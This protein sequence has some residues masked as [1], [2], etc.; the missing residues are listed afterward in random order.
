MAATPEDRVKKETKRLIKEV[1]D[2]RGLVY[3]IDW[4]AGSAFEQTLDATG[5]VAGHP[6]IAELKRFDQ[7][8]KLT[9]RQKL[10]VKAFRAAG[11]YVHVIDE[12]QCLVHLA[13]WLESLTPRLPHDP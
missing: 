2:R 9:G 10:K 7:D 4:H 6:F 13:F 12:P 5:V 8:A 1:C 11:A 3:E